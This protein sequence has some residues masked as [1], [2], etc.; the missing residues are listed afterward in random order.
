MTP[1][2]TPALNN[3]DMFAPAEIEKTIEHVEQIGRDDGERGAPPR[4]AS[5]KIGA[6][7]EQAWLLYRTRVQ[8]EIARAIA[9]VSLEQRLKN[10]AQPSLTEAQSRLATA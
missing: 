2:T 6:M 3:P 9:T 8:Q 1:L 4:G 5:G 7:A 10:D